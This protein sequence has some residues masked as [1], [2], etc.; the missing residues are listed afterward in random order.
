LLTKPDSKLAAKSEQSLLHN[1]T[2]NW[3][4]KPNKICAREI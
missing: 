1:F 4:Q 2:S 3:R